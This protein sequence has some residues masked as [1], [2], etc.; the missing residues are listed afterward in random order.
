MAI[1]GHQKQWNFLKQSVENNRVAHAYIFYGPTKIGKK[2]VALELAEMLTNVAG[3]S[4][5]VPD[6]TLVEPECPTDKGGETKSASRAVIHV[7]KIFDLKIKLSLSAMN[8]EYKVAIIEDA[9]TMTADAQGA[10][11]KLLEEPKGRTV[12]ILIAE[13]LETLTPTIASRCQHIRFD[14]LASRE[15]EEYLVRQKVSPQKAKELSWLSFGR[16]GLAQDYLNNP[17]EEKL[18][19]AKIEE[20]NQIIKAPLKLRFEYAQKLSQKREELNKALEVWLNY[21]RELLLEKL[22]EKRMPIVFEN[23]HYSTRDLKRNI[24]LIEKIKFVISSTN[25]NPRLALEILLMRI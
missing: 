4:A 11:L 6:L 19:R 3:E 22:G 17:I 14:L 16:P 21:F 18:Q 5:V 25:A 9:V 10:L 1:I 2:T 20:I 12:I 13:H 24:N 8:S 23:K 7:A 15:I